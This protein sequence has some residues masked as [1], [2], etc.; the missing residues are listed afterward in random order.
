LV[1]DV[2]DQ[3]IVGQ[4]ENPVQRERQFHHAEV[5]SEMTAVD[6]ARTDEH[7]ANLAGKQI[8]LRA[9]EALDVGGRSD[10]FYDH[11]DISRF[12][13]LGSN[14]GLPEPQA[15]GRHHLGRSPRE[16]R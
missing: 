9:L 7:A 14:S 5:W 6:G 16:A 10:S 12:V 4:I 3:L 2:P 13:A 11:G 1:A 8:D 15:A